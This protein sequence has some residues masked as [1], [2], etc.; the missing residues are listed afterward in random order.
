MVPKP[1][2]FPIIWLSKVK[3]LCSVVPPLVLTNYWAN[4]LGLHFHFFSSSTFQNENARFS[5][6][7][8]H[9]LNKYVFKARTIKVLLKY[10]LLVKVSNSILCLCLPLS[11]CIGCPICPDYQSK[12]TFTRAFLLGLCLATNLET[13]HNKCKVTQKNFL[14]WFELLKHTE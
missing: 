3:K 4:Y 11:P 8:L 12:L 10:T 6:T 13:S 5:S 1:W 9:K 2:T 7:H 14:L